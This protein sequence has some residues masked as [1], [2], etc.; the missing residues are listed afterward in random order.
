VNL[1]EVQAA[2]R[3][4]WH[5]DGNLIYVPGEGVLLLLVNESAQI[6]DTLKPMQSLPA[7]AL[8]GWRHER[9]CVGSACADE[10]PLAAA[11]AEPTAVRERKSSRGLAGLL[12]LRHAPRAH[13]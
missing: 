12:R 13:G 4:A 3:F 10:Y 5:T 6:Y 7:W 8:T 1:D 11:T 9:A 2:G